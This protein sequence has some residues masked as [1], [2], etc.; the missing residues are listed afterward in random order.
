M[1]L[2]YLLW[3]YALMNLGGICFSQQAETNS[4]IVNSMINDAV[5]ELQNRI[6]LN[7]DEEL[8]AFEY[9]ETDPE[10]VYVASVSR[11][12]LSSF[13]ILWNANDDS[14]I[15][16]IK[17]VKN[18][19]SVTYPAIENDNVL[20]TKSVKRNIKVDLVFALSGKGKFAEGG[21]L[22]YVRTSKSKFD[23]QMF[24]YVEDRPES[25]LNSR[26]PD[27]TSFN[28]VILPAIMIGLS[29]AAIILFFSIRSK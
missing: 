15:N 14:V 22:N 5:I 7:G 2:K 18:D 26:L 6:L 8:Y 21:D 3:F 29:A 12:L 17:L 19:I 4:Y 25:F 13:K 28:K 27:E 16:R 20:G 9:D 1:N 23:I 10:A 24:D 11:K